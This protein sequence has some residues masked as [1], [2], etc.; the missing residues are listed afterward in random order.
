MK[1]NDLTVSISGKMELSPEPSIKGHF[2]DHD[3]GDSKHA[4]LAGD[5]LSHE[6]GDTYVDHTEMSPAEQWT[7]IV[8]ALKY[9]GFEVSI[10]E[11]K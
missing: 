1:G 2:L 10:E 3:F 9:H 11:Q 6:I 7:R 8:E 4:M 5:I